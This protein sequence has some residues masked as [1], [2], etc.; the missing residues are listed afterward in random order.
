MR[1]ENVLRDIQTDCGNFRHGRLLKWCS[2]PPLWHIDAAGGGVHTITLYSVGA[3][4][5][6]GDVDDVPRLFWGGI[7]V[8]TIISTIIAYAFGLF[9]AI[10]VGLF[11]AIRDRHQGGNSLRSSLFAAFAFWLL[12]SVA[13]IAVVPPQG[14]VQWFGALLA[15]HVLA[16]AVCALF[17]RWIFR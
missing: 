16:A 3:T 11:N 1:V 12:T 13:A 14:L 2:T 7:V 8:G 5:A 15:G 10:G 9:S 4:I 17:A 6:N